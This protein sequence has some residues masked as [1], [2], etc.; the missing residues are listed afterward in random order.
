MG[1]KVGLGVIVTEVKSG[2]VA[3]KCGLK[4]G[5]QIFQVHFQTIYKHIY[6]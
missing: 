2:G 3:A 4:N 5:D 6:I 1:M